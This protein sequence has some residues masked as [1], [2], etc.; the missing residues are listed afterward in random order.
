MIQFFAVVLPVLILFCGLSIDIGM[1]EL[2]KLQMQSAADAAALGAELEAERGT[3][4]WVNIGIAEA[5]VNGFTNGSNNTTV[6]IVERATSGAYSGRYDAIQATITQSVHTVF[7]GAFNG[8]VFNLTAQSSALMTPCIYTLGNGTLQ[9]Y[10]L[11]VYTGSLLADSCPIYATSEDVLSYGNV[12]VESVDVSG[13]SSSS[14]NAGFIYPS[15]VFNVPAL[16]DP[17]A[18]VTSPSYGGSCTHT[19]Y[20]LTSGSA[21]LSPGTF[22]KG[23]NISN[24]TVTL[25]PG[26]YTI[27][28]GANWSNATVSGTGVTLFF[29]TGGGGGYGQFLIQNGSHVTISAANDSVTGTI[30][31]LST[32]LVFADR[33]WTATSGQDFQIISSTISGDG[34]WYLPHAGFELWSDGTYTAPHY[35][36]VVSDNIFTAGTYFEPVNNYSYVVNGNPFRRFGT[37]VQ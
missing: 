31:A 4:N 35:L 36:G 14:S 16:T 26:L 1:L 24:A 30:P 23:L 28:G 12:A 29:T 19:S 5:G 15:P 9:N 37:L 18:N 32:I 8:G 34:I 27:T 2:K 25:N 13:S 11:M 20:S 22:C 17:L 21:T 33:N 6:S 7:M 10:S 3:G